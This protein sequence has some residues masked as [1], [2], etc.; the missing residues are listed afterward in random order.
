M[1]SVGS[2]IRLT[3][4]VSGVFPDRTWTYCSGGPPRRFRESVG[5][6]STSCDKQHI[7]RPQRPEIFAGLRLRFC[8]FAIRTVTE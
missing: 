2:V 4:S 1:K 8:L 6:S 5:Y 3:D 7:S